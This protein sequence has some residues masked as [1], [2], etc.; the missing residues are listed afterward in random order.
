MPAAKFK[1]CIS[2]SNIR[3]SIHTIR[4]KQVRKNPKHY[5][6]Y[7]KLQTDVAM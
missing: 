6:N 5:L 2:T 1:I 7:T 3:G 4:G